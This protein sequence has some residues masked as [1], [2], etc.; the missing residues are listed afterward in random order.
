MSAS[1]LGGGD[2]W[3]GSRLDGTRGRFRGYFRDVKPGGVRAL[4]WAS[5]QVA[6][7]ADGNRGGHQHLGE[8]PQVPL[9]TAARVVDRAPGPGNVDDHDGAVDDGGHVGWH[10]P[11][12]KPKRSFLPRDVSVL[13]TGPALATP[14]QQ[15]HGHEEI[16]QVDHHHG[17][18]W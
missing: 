16:G 10:A 11:A 3:D 5:A 4:S 2:G 1:F 9:P 14:H 17:P 6:D 8:V 7:P 13:A 15:R 18:H 12:T